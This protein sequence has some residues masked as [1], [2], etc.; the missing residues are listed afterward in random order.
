[1]EISSLLAERKVKSSLTKHPPRPHRTQP[2]TDR[3]HRWRFPSGRFQLSPL[4]LQMTERND[5]KGCPEHRNTV[6][7]CS[8]VKARGGGATKIHLSSKVLNTGLQCCISIC[9]ANW[10]LPL[11]WGLSYCVP[12]FT[13]FHP[14]FPVSTLISM[15]SVFYSVSLVFLHWV[16]EVLGGTG[17]SLTAA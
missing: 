14:S 13:W 12:D 11:S 6:V 8:Q 10:S 16:L 2:R 17:V 9:K 3:Y 4:L 7:T 1:M 5:Q 15:D